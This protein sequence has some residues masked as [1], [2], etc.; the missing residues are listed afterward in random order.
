MTSTVKQAAA[1]S[2]SYYPS[3]L[4]WSPGYGDIHFDNFK[5]EK[6][7]LTAGFAIS[8]PITLPTP[9]GRLATKQVIGSLL[10]DTFSRW[11]AYC[12]AFC[13][14]EEILFIFL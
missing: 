14:Q 3:M 11:P 13:C 8:S 1:N 5:E 9:Q 12:S 6:P 10:P 2:K 4:R 7:T